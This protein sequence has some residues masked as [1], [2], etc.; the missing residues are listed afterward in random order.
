MITNSICPCCS[1][2]NI[3]V[4]LSRKNV[5]VYQNIVLRN[6]EQAINIIRGN[7]EMMLCQ[8]CGFIFNHAF[9]P[10]KMK[11]GQNYDNLQICSELFSN[12]V[13]GL[14]QSIVETS[15]IQASQIVEIGCGKG[16]FLKKL[17]TIKGGEENTGYGFDPSYEGEETDLDGRLTYYKEYYTPESTHITADAVV[18]R[19]VIE[20]YPLPIELLRSI[21]LTLSGSLDAKIF[22]ETPCAQWILKNNAIW[23][24]FYEHC[25][26][27]TKNSL[28]TAFEITGFTVKKISHVFNGQ[29]L[30]LEA[31]PTE[32]SSSKKISAGEIPEL[33]NLFSKEET[34][35]KKIWI[36]KI[37][38]L[39]LS[40]NVAIWGAG[41][42]GVTFVNLIDPEDNKIKCVFD[43]NP[44]K[45]NGFIPGTGHPIFSPT[46]LKHLKI[47]HIV[48]MNPNYKEEVLEFLNRE[49]HFETNLIMSEVE[50]DEIDN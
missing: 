48:L 30:W 1:S 5:P 23:D 35:F 41:A 22:F 47:K 29:Y 32:D 24:F 43:I 31:I 18:C 39:K 7:L 38:R 20:H 26:L 25:S 16:F 10:E 44:N 49:R 2:K 11:Y 36:K 12:Y 17:L 40:G 8:S 19:H 14:A 33:T 34:I 37:N 9:E 46:E 3:R 13:D 6:K 27:F 50:K 28:K 15:E 21:R 42:K 4:F 45:Q